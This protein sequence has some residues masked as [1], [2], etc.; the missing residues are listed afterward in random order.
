MGQ[1]L[2]CLNETD[3]PKFCSRSCNASYTNKHSPRRKAAIRLCKCGLVLTGRAKVCQACSPYRDM[4]VAEAMYEYTHKA[5]AYGL[6]RARA[7]ISV[8]TE[9][10]CCEVCG[11]D[12]HVEVA[13]VNAIASYPVDTMISVIN[14]RDNLRILCPNCHWEFDNL[15][16]SPV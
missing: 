14:K 11:Y 16:R 8:K 1:C 10:D 6:I 5:S 7:R 12:K 3:N 4:T 13:H 2:H 9:L 15:P